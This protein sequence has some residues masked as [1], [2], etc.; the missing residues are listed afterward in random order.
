MKMEIWHHRNSIF[1]LEKA[2][3]QKEAATFFML[4][5]I[6]VFMAINMTGAPAGF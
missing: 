1:A 2:G 3:D 5:S 6:L 4:L